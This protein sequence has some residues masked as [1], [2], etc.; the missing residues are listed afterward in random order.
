AHQALPR[1]YFPHSYFCALRD[2]L[3]H[4]TRFVFAEHRN[5]IIASTLYLH[6]DTD[7]FSFLGGAES[8]FQHLR[9]SNAVIWDT[10]QWARAAGK[11]RLILGGGY[12]PSDGV[13]RFKTTFSRLRRAFYL[14]RRV[15]F[16]Q[17]YA[18]LEHQCREYYRVAELPQSY[19]P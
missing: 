6:D 2:E 1:Y 11:K 9:P 13:F 15:H 3:P 16:E 14:Y 17:D 12:K 18:R 7:V 19:F 8:A 5:Q 10:I 4:N